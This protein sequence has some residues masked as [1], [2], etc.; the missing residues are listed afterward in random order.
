M[1]FKA[2]IRICKCLLL[3]PTTNDMSLNVFLFFFRYIFSFIDL[4]TFS[5]VLDSRHAPKG[6]ISK[7]N[8]T[9]ALRLGCCYCMNIPH[10]ERMRGEENNK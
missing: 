1:P 9:L 2:L 7:Y 3:R 5:A 4:M 10:C 6:T 8:V